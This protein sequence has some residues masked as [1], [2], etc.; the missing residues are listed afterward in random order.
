MVFLAKGWRCSSSWHWCTACL[1]QACRAP[2]LWLLHVQWWLPVMFLKSLWQYQQSHQ[3]GHSEC[4]CWSCG[5]ICGPVSFI[6]SYSTCIE[7]YTAVTLPCSAYILNC[8][9]TYDWMLPF[10]NQTCL[11]WETKKHFLWTRNSDVTPPP[12][13]VMNSPWLITPQ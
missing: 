7:K 3:E 1:T 10:K 13:P 6:Y 12:P 11:V 4:W 8:L 5:P 2:W 9:N